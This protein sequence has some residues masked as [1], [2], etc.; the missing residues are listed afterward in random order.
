ML[1][2]VNCHTSAK[3]GIQ[4]VNSFTYILL[5]IQYLATKDIS[6]MSKTRHYIYVHKSVH[7]RTCTGCS[8]AGTLQEC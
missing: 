3:T 4:Y 8:V 5:T 2:T 1:L 7:V 6:S